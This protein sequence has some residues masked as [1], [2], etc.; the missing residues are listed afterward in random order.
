MAPAWLDE[1]KFTDGSII[2]GP[3]NIKSMRGWIA[4][5]LVLGL[6]MAGCASQAPQGGNAS[7]SS[8]TQGG[9]QP[10]MSGNATPPSPPPVENLSGIHK[11]KHVV[12][13]MQENRAF[14]EYFGTYPGADG[15]PRY[16]NGSFSTCSP[17]LNGTCIYPYHDYYDRNEGGPHGADQ[18]V[19]DIN[20]GSMDGFVMQQELGNKANC[21]GA[22][23]PNCK[24]GNGR[25]DVMGYHD[26]GE[27]PNYWAYA[28]NFVLNDHMFEAAASWSLPSH[29]FLVSE[30]SGKCTSDDPS[31]C[32]D[33]LA[34]PQSLTF[35]NTLYKYPN[36]T[37]K[38]PIYAWT[39]IT[40]L[41]HKNNVSWG[42]YVDEGYQPDC[43]DDSM[44]CTPLVQ[45]AAVPQ[46]WNPL[47]WFT[48]VREDNET[49]NVQP[50]DNFFVAAKN[51]DLPAVT[52]IV[53]NQNDSEHPFALVSDG[54]RYTTTLIN[55]IME[56]PDWNSTAI[57]LTWDDWGGFYDHVEPPKVDQNGFGLRVPA[58]VISPYARQGYIDS[59]NASFDAYTKFI[60]EDFLNGSMLDPAT[61]GRPDP[62]TDVRESLD[63][64]DLTKD[65]DFNQSPRPPLILNP[66][67]KTD[68]IPP[69]SAENKDMSVPQ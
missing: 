20:N 6:I 59:Q 61:D 28:D 12:I 38:P 19:K 52:W 53:P 30:W 26:R 32:A 21:K 45:K 60:E 13:I 67:P 23:N 58:M 4:V 66:D 27:I 2:K 16:P 62:R 24:Q 64:G 36:G 15:L 31:S 11:I 18:T 56:G 42:Y 5:I 14:D 68:L 44:Y 33:E 9:P 41:L 43:E 39:D 40:Y 47:P 22:Q 57:F 54:Q 50:L 10:N 7:N 29:L 51:G 69:Q 65:F 63:V 48:D 37:V 1:G 8:G 46:I 34:T 55:A 3:K 17:T 25:N 35:P 49:S